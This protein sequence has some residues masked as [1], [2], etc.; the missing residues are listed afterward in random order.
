M[1]S[2]GNSLAVACLLAALD[3]SGIPRKVFASDLGL[4]EPELS[5]ALSSQ[6]FDIRWL[7][8]LPPVVALDWFTRYARQKFGA[9]VRLPEPEDLFAHVLAQ[10]GTLTK[11]VQQAQELSELRARRG[12]A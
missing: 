4:T 8:E 11:Q 2:H 3:E 7:D 5:K 10:I 9:H 6:R 12:A 1:A